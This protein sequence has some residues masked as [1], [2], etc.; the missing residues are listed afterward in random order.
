MR[1][2]IFLLFI[3][4]PF[5]SHATDMCARNDTMVMVFDPELGIKDRSAYAGDWR[6]SFPYGN[7]SGEYTC[8]SAAEGLGRTS[9]TGVP[10]YG[11]GEYDKTFINATAG[12]KGVDENDNERK[13]CW[14]RITH[15]LQSKWMFVSSHNNSVDCE[16]GC[17]GYFM[18][19]LF[20]PK[21]LT[22]YFNSIGL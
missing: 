10:Y 22:F 3:F 1:Y 12:L 20:T 5:I 19:G 7:F 2:V 8:L 16:S 4:I 21:N 13:Y 11:V 18:C 9:G 14:C 17:P 6:A 15:P